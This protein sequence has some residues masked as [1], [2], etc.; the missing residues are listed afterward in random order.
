[1]MTIQTVSQVAM[2]MRKRL[3]TDNSLTAAYCQTI[4]ILEEED[5]TSIV[6]CFAATP[7]LHK[8]GIAPNTACFARLQKKHF[9]LW[10]L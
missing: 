6:E 10:A 2:R 3:A 5:M 4:R 7:G 1:M 9:P 8:S